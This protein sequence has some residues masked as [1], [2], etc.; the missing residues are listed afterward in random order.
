MQE[1][2]FK[3]WIGLAF[4]AHEK[5]LNIANDSVGQKW[6]YALLLNIQRKNPCSHFGQ[7]DRQEVQINTTKRY[8]FAPV[9]TAI[10]SK[11]KNQK[12]KTGRGEKGALLH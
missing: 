9:R 5:L 1:P 6:A 2:D 7:P 12:W 11:C 8:H 10:L 4:K 3:R